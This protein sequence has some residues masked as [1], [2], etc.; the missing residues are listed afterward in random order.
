V[1]LD[2]DVADADLGPRSPPAVSPTTQ[3]DEAV[4][5]V[6]RTYWPRR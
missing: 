2:G 5:V 1:F 6:V 4:G 3:G